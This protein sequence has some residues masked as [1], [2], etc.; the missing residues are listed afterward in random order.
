MIKQLAK[1]R[2]IKA[3]LFDLDGTLIRVQMS[4]YIP[5]YIDGLAIY[6]SDLVKPKKF[7]Q[8]MLDSIRILIQHGGDGLQTNEQRVFST[9]QHQLAIPENQLRQCFDQFRCEGMAEMKDL[10][11]PIPLA[12]EII[13]ECRQLDV[14]LVLATNS[15]FPA[16]MIE[17][18]LQWGA[19]DDSLFCHLTSFE[20][21]CYCKPHVGYFRE[22]SEHLGI[23]AED[24]LMVG[25]DTSH[26]LAA[27][28]IGMQTF[29]V[30]TWIVKRDGIA[31]SCD[32]QGDHAALQLFLRQ[33][34]GERD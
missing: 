11:Q 19:L 25:N 31:W 14:P 6:C 10:V 2:A 23:A 8:A 30:D 33:R 22:I 17:A 27:M 4:K 16:F 34:L 29:L 3:I 12:R 20:N 7:H 32:H 1:N 18:R 28:E 9:L 15:V 13:E 5:R 21:S 24:C 26:D